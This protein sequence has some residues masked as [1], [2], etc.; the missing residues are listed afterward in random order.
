MMLASGTASYQVK[1]ALKKVEGKS[2][3]VKGKIM[4]PTETCEFLLAIPLK[5]FDSGDSN[6]DLNMRSALEADKYPLAQARGSFPIHLLK[7][8]KASLEA[9]V[10]L[11]GVTQVYP[12]TLQ[13]Q[14]SKAR[15]T[16]K[17][18]AHKVERPSLLGIK[19]GNEVPVEFDLKWAK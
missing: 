9:K 15:F 3:Q 18:E 5:S 11:H 12:V 16:L 4:C 2:S 17:L 19:I 6:R 1:Y 7:Q 14:G 10:E 8:D 13:Q